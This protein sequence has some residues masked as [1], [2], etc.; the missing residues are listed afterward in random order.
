MK[1]LQNIEIDGLVFLGCIY[2]R[3]T[4]DNT[5]VGPIGPMGAGK[6]RAG[7][8]VRALR[9]HSANFVITLA[10]NSFIL[11][12]SFPGPVSV[13]HDLTDNFCDP[14]RYTTERFASFLTLKQLRPR[15]FCDSVVRKSRG[16]LL[17]DRFGFKSPSW[18]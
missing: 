10:T 13:A 18:I 6:L 16:H 14:G 7:V 12:N 15:K 3:L 5:A 11:A 9:Q 4:T 8:R 1:C 2:P 17:R